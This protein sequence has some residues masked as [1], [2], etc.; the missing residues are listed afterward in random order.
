MSA[1]QLEQTFQ[2]QNPSVVTL[3]AW[4]GSTERDESPLRLQT[5]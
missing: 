5:A 3:P 4:E 1:E 2:S